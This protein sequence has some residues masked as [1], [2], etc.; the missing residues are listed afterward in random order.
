MK[1]FI[2]MLINVL[3]KPYEVFALDDVDSKGELSNTK[4]NVRTI[5]SAKQDI[6]FYLY[7]WKY[8]LPN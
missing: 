8:G 2:P 3:D 6:L 1:K 7:G 5:M 4:E